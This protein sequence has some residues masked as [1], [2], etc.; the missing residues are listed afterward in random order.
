MDVLSL[1]GENAFFEGKLQRAG[2]ILEVCHRILPKR[3]ETKTLLAYT[4]HR[5]E[6]FGKALIYYRDIA[7]T[8]E[9]PRLERSQAYAY[10]ANN[11]PQQAWRVFLDLAKRGNLRAGQL[12]A[13]GGVLPG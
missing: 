11:Q 1:H 6:D 2:R 5:L 4:F 7:W 3:V 9:N 8:D 13:A 12:P 10:M